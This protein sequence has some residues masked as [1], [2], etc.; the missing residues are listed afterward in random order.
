[1]T[2]LSDATVGTN[3]LLRL[4][5]RRDRIVL[6]IWV[7][8]LAA[9]TIGTEFSF[10]GLYSTV[11]ERVRFASAL[12]GNPTLIALTGRMF[13]VTTSGGLT[14]WRIGAS[15][16]MFLGL[17]NI[18]LLVRHTRAEEE[19]GRLELVGAGVVGRRAPLTAALQLVLTG[20]LLI[21]IVIAA[22]LMAFG[23]SPSGS[24]ALG[25]GLAAVGACFAGVAA[26]AAQ[27]TES[28]RAANGSA[29]TVLVV[30]YLLRAIGDAAAG[31]A[32]TGRGLSWLSW[33]SP[34]GWGQQIRAFGVERWWVFAPLVGFAVVTTSVAYVLV[35]RRDH[36]AGLFPA[37]PGPAIA[38]PSLRGAFS[39][40]FR[41]QRGGLLGWTIGFALYGLVIGAVAQD[42]ASL[43]NGS[44][45]LKDIIAKL[46][47]SSGLV[48]AFIAAMVGMMGLIAAFSVVQGGLR[49]RIEETSQRAEPVLATKVGR[50]RFAASHLV[51]S[52]VGALVMLAA[53][54]AAAGLVH[55]LR[56]GDV[57]HQ[58]PRVLLG[59][60][61]Q[62]PAVWVVAGITV[63][64]LGF[65]PRATSAAWAVAAAFVVVSEFGPAFHAPQWLMDVSPFTHVPKVPGATVAA[66]PIIWLLAVA[67]VLVVAGLVGF[68]RR[69]IG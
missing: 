56:T 51:V 33:L 45:Q 16:G 34:I 24:I 19:A 58:L 2:A 9:L 68:R 6:P 46:G 52:A 49:P 30:A 20:D 11:D 69:D 21:G 62:V 53:A 44:G 65:L 43:A 8:G 17:M 61:V 42:L 28:S 3:T 32:D 60:L 64:L 41:L 50:V 13:A 12:A 15:A 23:E 57:G 22:G 1:M 40:A 59:A 29:S 27:L 38:A 35:E 25:L 63:L 26:I 10:K 66:T 54:G 14:A 39:L 55:G 18:F 67:A 5:F 31:S 47:G 4:G 36:G 37:R 7:Y 48:D